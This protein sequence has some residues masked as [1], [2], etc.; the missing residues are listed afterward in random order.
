MDGMESEN[1]T[2]R[3]TGKIKHANFVTGIKSLAAFVF[4][5]IKRLYLVSKLI[6]SSQENPHYQA[7]ASLL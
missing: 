6:F 5:S 1:Q 4:K 2:G 7:A 3:M